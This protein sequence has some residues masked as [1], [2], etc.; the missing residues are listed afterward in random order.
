MVIVLGPTNNACREQHQKA[1]IQRQV[2]QLAGLVGWLLAAGWLASW[3][4]AGRAGFPTFPGDCALL[5]AEPVLVWCVAAF[6]PVSQPRVGTRRQT[7]LYRCQNIPRHSWL[8]GALTAVT[9]DSKPRGF[10]ITVV[11]FS[12]SAGKIQ[13]STRVTSA[14]LF[15]QS[16]SPSSVFEVVLLLF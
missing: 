10:I 7:Y 15:P 13:L 11:R 12:D 1:V 8:S 2:W 6:P 3:L 4:A 5:A 9:F 16:K 14:C